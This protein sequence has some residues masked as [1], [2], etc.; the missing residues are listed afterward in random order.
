MLVLLVLAG[1]ALAL[2]ALATLGLVA[3]VLASLAL[4][5]VG[6]VLVATSLVHVIGHFILRHEIIFTRMR[7]QRL[8]MSGRLRVSVFHPPRCPEWQGLFLGTGVSGEHDSGGTRFAQRSR[9]Y[10]GGALYDYLPE[11]NALS[12]SESI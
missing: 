12:V 3:L 2:G 9:I 4:T 10:H 5:T 1:A 6:L 11:T 8:R 7:K